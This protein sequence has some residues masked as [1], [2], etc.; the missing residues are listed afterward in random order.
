MRDIL[1]GH[2]CRGAMNMRAHTHGLLML[3]GWASLAAACGKS[4]G[5]KST[6]DSVSDAATEDGAGDMSTDS[7][8]GDW[9]QEDQ[10]QD[11]LVPPKDGSTADS[12]DSLD[13]EPWPECPAGVPEMVC[14]LPHK[15]P[16]E[17]ER[18]ADGE[19][20]SQQEVRDFTKGL[21]G[22]WKQMDYFTWLYETNH[23]MDASTGYPEYLIWW[24]DVD[25]VKEGDTVT[26]R[27]NRNHGGSHNNAEP[28]SLAMAQVAGGYLLTGDPM[29]GEVLRQFALSFTAMMKGFEF[30]ANDPN[31]FI[32]ARNIT[33]HNHSFTLP[34]G[35]K[36]AVDFTDW[37]FEYEGWNA[38]RYL[39]KDNPTWGEI[40]VT[41]MRSKDD[42]PYMFRAT[43]W[44][45]YVI[46]R[47]DNQDVREGLVEAWEYMAGFAQ[48]IVAEGWLIRTKDRDG[49]PYV[50]ETE[51]LASFVEYTS[52]MPD[53]ECDGR[54]AVA[55]LASG[56]IPDFD[57]G[58]GQGSMYDDVSGSINYYNY[59]IVDG[60][61]MNAVHLAL[62]M[63]HSELAK[64][65]LEGL[66]IRIDRYRNPK[67]CGK[68]CLNEN[69]GRDIATLLVEAACVGL[70]LTAAEARHVH[71]YYNQAVV[72]FMAFPNWDLWAP[73]VA[74]GVYDFR[75]GFHPKAN[76]NAVRV[77]EIALMMEYCASPFQNPAGAQ[78]VDCDLV[79]DKAG[80]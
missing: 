64:R 51:D 41:T 71:T 25:A 19:P 13:L 56:K 48:D 17:F 59:S 2:I 15:L 37:W 16:F 42:L 6:V 67:T 3:L 73:S 44:L 27:H 11:G 50:P 66:A 43:A 14:N 5:T 20:L 78:F 72:D 1:P 60:F 10:L 34:S 62:V 46:L 24:H 74:D 52:V 22:V 75:Q 49:N 63:G 61:H 69:W 8:S 47:T 21:T 30:D 77:E 29:A 4:D 35:K 57:C 38:N 79:A 80:W 28:T 45:P 23:G 54:L 26:F 68:G 32:M 31:K 36:K 7:N 58:N 40:W 76:P 70:P 53:A 9:R 18:K 12:D 65:L 33:G 55:L 39:Y